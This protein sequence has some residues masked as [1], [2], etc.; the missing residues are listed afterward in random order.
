MEKK[1]NVIVRCSDE[2]L[3]VTDQY[4]QTEFTLDRATEVARDQAVVCDS[5]E[6]H[7]CEVGKARL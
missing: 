5:I 2:D 1:Y 3:L 4:G 6:V 7:I